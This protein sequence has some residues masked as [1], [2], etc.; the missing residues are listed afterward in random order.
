MKYSENS[1]QKVGA[2]LCIWWT[3]SSS[4]YCC[5]SLLVVC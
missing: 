1:C 5:H 4:A 3:R 2:C